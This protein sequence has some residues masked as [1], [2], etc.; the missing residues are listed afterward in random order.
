MTP[1]DLKHLSS[2]ELESPIYDI[3]ERDATDE[4]IGQFINSHLQK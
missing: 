1:L 3:D 4:A 2:E